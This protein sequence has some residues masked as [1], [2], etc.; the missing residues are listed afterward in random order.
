MSCDGKPRGFQEISP[1]SPVSSLN[2]EPL[3]SRLC[4][5][6]AGRVK[7]SLEQGNVSWE[8]PR[9]LGQRGYIPVCFLDRPLAS[10]LPTQG[11]QGPPEGRATTLKWP[12]QWAPGLIGRNGAARG[13][14]PPPTT[15]HCPGPDAIGALPD[16]SA[17]RWAA[18]DG[19]GPGRPTSRGH[20]AVN[21]LQTSP[22]SGHQRP[23]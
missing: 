5:S 6:A 19:A 14:G 2:R 16:V 17:Q 8:G 15:P 7:S 9:L 3:I 20:W 18:E 11:P 23:Q 22:C 4:V 12:R 21:C 10:T 13:L 1:P